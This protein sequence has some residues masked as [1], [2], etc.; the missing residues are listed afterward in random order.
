MI[1]PPPPSGLNAESQITFLI[2]ELGIPGLVVMAA[3]TLIVLGLVLARIRRTGSF[4]EVLLIGGLAAP[5]FSLAALWV[6]GT[7][8]TSSPTAPYFWLATGALSFWLCTAV[9][10]Q[11]APS[12]PTH[13]T[14]LQA[15]APVSAIS[16]SGPGR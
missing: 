5:L 15:T 14:A 8:T 4:E 10:R 9:G 7:N 12:P 11:P 2:V 1:D 13:R 6:V 16:A 3:L